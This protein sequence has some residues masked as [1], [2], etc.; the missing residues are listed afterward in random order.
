MEILTNISLSQTEAEFYKKFKNLSVNEQPMPQGE[1]SIR[2]SPFDDYFI[3]TLYD[4]ID[5]VDSPI[6]LSN[7]GTIF[8]VFIGTNDEIRIPNYTN[9]QD[10]DL[11]S[12]QVLFRI[13]K[14][15]SQ[16][17][18][19]LNNRNFYISTRMTDPDGSSD[20]S[21][22]Y[23]GTF[24]TFNAAAKTSLTQQLEDTR[25]GYSRQ[26][27][28]L[29]ATIDRLNQDIFQKDNLIAE[30]TAIIETLKGSNQN[31][32]NEIAVL[33]DKV[34]SFSAQEL[35]Q[36]AKD[37]QQAEELVKRA[38]LQ[39]KSISEVGLAQQTKSKKQAFVNQAVKQLRSNIPGVNPVTSGDRGISRINEI[40]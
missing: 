40:R 38:R 37:V 15:E 29:K 33:A 14:N 17:I 9:V 2:I 25:L 22:L 1:G 20:E 39:V 23:T 35:L 34:P 24:M 12:G 36:E 19:A 5:N 7:V 13:S 10:V 18:L 16:K 8:M 6:D 28:S 3:F 27:A 30:Q 21:V 26:L 4:E 32:S 31:L 11:S